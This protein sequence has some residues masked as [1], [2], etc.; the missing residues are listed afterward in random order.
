MANYIKAYYVDPISGNDRNIGTINNPFKT[1]QKGVDAAETNNNDSNKIHLK[2]GT[3]YLNRTLDIDSGGSNNAYLT[4]QP[5]SGNKVILD[6]SNISGANNL[7][8]IRDANY[9]NITGLEINNAPRH[10]IEVINGSHINITNNLVHDTEGMGIRV[11]GYMAIEGDTSVQSS[12]VLIKNNNVYYTN[13]DNSGSNKGV[14][15]WGAAIQAWN[16]NQVKIVNNTVSKNY[17]EGIGLTLVDNG[18]VS[19]NLLYD[20]FSIQL[21]LD[22]VTDSFVGANYIYNSGD[23][24]FYRN[25]FSAHGIGLANEIHDIATPNL[26][27][28]NNN[29]IR[30]NVIVGVNTGIIYG[31]WGGIHQENPNHHQGLKNT[32]IAH[33]TIYNSEFHSLRFF[34]DSNNQNV[35]VLNNIFAQSGYDLSEIDDLTGINFQRNLWFGGNPGEGKSLTDLVQNP[36]F[37]NPGGANLADYRLQWNSPAIDAVNSSNNIWVTDGQPDLGALEFGQPVFEVGD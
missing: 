5:L 23:R 30:R 14:N 18:V 10:G 13:L 17:G 37:V 34:A 24:R 32:T 11:R 29:Q 33:N 19:K 20:N 27:S 25:N 35:R 16:A 28:L 6:G 36:L 7:I 8:N 31:T 22:N 15:N 4:I 1:I 21:Y 3:Y 12:H 9:I 26:F 2:G